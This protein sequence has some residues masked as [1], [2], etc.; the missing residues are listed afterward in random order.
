MKINSL[1]LKKTVWMQR[2]LALFLAGGFFIAVAPLP[3]AEIGLKAGANLSFAG[4]SSA[5][6]N[7]ANLFGSQGGFF[8]S[9]PLGGLFSLDP[10]INY[11]M[12]GGRYYSVYSRSTHAARFHYLEIPLLLNLSL[13]KKLLSFFIGPYY[14]ILLGS[15]P[16][17]DEHDWSWK[18]NKLKRSD[19]GV[20][21]GVRLRLKSFFVEMQCTLGLVNVITNPNEADIYQPQH[22]NRCI[23]LLIGYV[24]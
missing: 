3:A 9:V 24:F 8:V 20:L 4:E 15:T 7:A 13:K 23:A 6:Y 22:K 10:G 12:R 5:I 1:A 11:V 16:L 18:E 14:G 17:D 2:A 21:G 19:A